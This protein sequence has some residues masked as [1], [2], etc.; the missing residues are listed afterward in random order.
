MKKMMVVVVVLLGITI[1]I[2]LYCRETYTHINFNDKESLAEAGFR[3][4]YFSRKDFDEEYNESESINEKTPED[5]G[6]TADQV[7]TEDDE[8]AEKTEEEELFG[9]EAILKCLSEAE[10]V[11]EARALELENL[12]GMLQGKIEVEEAYKGSEKLER[13]DIIYVLYRTGEVSCG[14]DKILPMSNNFM[15]CSLFFLNPV[16]F[17]GKELEDV[18]YLADDCYLP[19][20]PLATPNIHYMG[21]VEPDEEGR[22]WYKDVKKY[23]YFVTD[24][25]ALQN[26]LD[27]QKK[28]SLEITE[29]ETTE[30]DYGRDYD[31]EYYFPEEEDEIKK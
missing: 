25:V 3:V 24:K 27:I 2:G 1:G 23:A 20:I 9:K 12:G 5:Y 11:V 18:F 10:Y 29:L 26:L 31:V 13:D 14:E 22:V 8:G 21:F 19:C 7:L 16:K 28:I 4:G 6:Y 15:S 30:E 17:K